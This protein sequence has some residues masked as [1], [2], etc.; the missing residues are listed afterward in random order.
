MRGAGSETILPSDTS[1]FMGDAVFD[2]FER[3][4]QPDHNFQFQPTLFQL[5]WQYFDCNFYL[6]DLTWTC[7]FNV[8]GDSSVMIADDC[9]FPVS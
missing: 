4:K 2:M 3:F 5:Q 8:V 7:D 6:I 9:L 1:S